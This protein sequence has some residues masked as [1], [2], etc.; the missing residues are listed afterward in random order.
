MEGSF[1]K[2]LKTLRGRVKQLK[3]SDV[4]KRLNVSVVSVN[5]W[6][7]DFNKPNMRNLKSL[8]SLLF[9]E[10]AFTSVEEIEQLWQATNVPI[11]DVWLADLIKKDAPDPEL[12]LASAAAV[13]ALPSQEEQPPIEAEAIVAPEQPPASAF[14]YQN[15]LRLLQ[16]VRSFWITGVFEQS[17]RGMA[18]I[19]LGLQ[20]QPDAV[21]NP[22]RLIIQESEQTSAPLPAGTRITEVYDAAGGELLILG[23]PGAGKT[24]LL[25]ELGRDLL[26]RA[27]QDPAHPIPVVFNLSSWVR[28]KRQSL[29]LWL[30]EELETKYH[31]PRSVGS[32]WIRA[33][34]ILPLLDGLDEV[35]A[36]SCFACF[37]AINEYHQGHSLVPLVVCCRVNDYRSQANHLELSRAVT[38]QPLTNEQITAY[39]AQIG[40]RVVSLR[41]AFDHDP[42]LQELSTTPLMLTILVLV[43][44]D[45]SLEEIKG[46]GSA[47]VRKSQIFATYTQ[48]ML[49]RRKAESGYS[50]EQT[51]SW[52][53]HLAR[54]MKQQS[55]TIFSLEQMQPGWLMKKWQR[56]LYYGLI[57]GP[58]CGLFVGLAALGTILSFPLIVLI[59][60]FIVGLLFGWGSELKTEQ[61]S[62]KTTMRL[63]VRIRESL[64]H[65]LENR[66]RIGVATGLFIGMSSFLYLYIGDFSDW[67]L[68]SRIAGA[69]ASSLPN[70]LCIGVCVGLTVGLERKIEP[71]EVSGWSWT[72]MRR[73]I[74]RWMLIGIGVVLEVMAIFPFLF[75]SHDASLA[76]FL[77]FA[78]SSVFQLVL[79]IMLISGVT[80]GLS[81]RTPDVQQTV[82]PNQGIWRSAR[83]GVVMAL[84]T[85]GI[86]A[87]LTGASDFLAYYWFPLHLGSS[88][89]PLGIDREAVSIMS[90]LLRVSPTTLQEFWILH[91]L[92]WGLT[93]AAIPALAV[94]LACG[95]AAFV[96][97]FVLRCL[98]WCARCIPFNYARFLD[99]AAERILLRKVG[100]GYIFIHR[101]LLEY[102]AGVQAEAPPSANTSSKRGS[103]KYVQ[104]A[105]A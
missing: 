83:Y 74:V 82:T 91:A 39:F 20:E 86:A 35:D 49:R 9:V 36:N 70:G 11:D 75:S 65:T 87:I 80:G 88:I 18:L 16:R 40:E 32:D 19:A 56:R 4:A 17:L 1:G 85:A 44:Q 3:Q 76:G 67:T 52:L 2:Q 27:E 51:I 12:A 42:V 81:M 66:T 68:G 78:L 63:W 13:V 53:S 104:S 89:K 43:Y 69:F 34:Q 46:G 102:F 61:K 48:R 25:L 5:Y 14:L 15:R 101:L 93:D 10:G 21:A 62:T 98:L 55:Q 24:T 47:E 71:V 79:V 23:E 92:F 33:N 60:A 8:I 94:G 97:H 50:P 31:V 28:R 58:I 77:A 64:A 54:Q 103:H 84:I 26:S 30:I 59:A 73:G 38:I 6:E 45:T 90:H 72:K 105:G 99:Y 22:W 41:I 7:N 96:Q 29:A 100:G 57:T 37:Q 95:G